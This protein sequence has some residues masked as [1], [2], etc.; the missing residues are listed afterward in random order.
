MST[1]RSVTV[2]V[3]TRNEADNVACLLARLPREVGEVIFVDDS[4]DETPA[5]IVE[6]RQ[7][8]AVPLIMIHRLP[9]DRVGGLS[10]AVTEG[11]RAASLSWV[12]VI[13]GDLQHPPEV[14]TDLVNCAVSTDVDIVVACR[15]GDEARAAMP[16][17]RQALSSIAGRAAH[18]AF[19]RR[20]RTADPMSGCFMIRRSALSID[21][22]RADGFKILLEVLVTHPEALVA[23]V[24]YVFAQRLHGHSKGTFREGLRYGRHLVGLYVRAGRRVEV[25]NHGADVPKLS[26]SCVSDGAPL[27]AGPPPHAFQ[28]RSGLPQHVTGAKS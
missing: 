19:R 9:G 10:G 6:A 18:V 26:H 2:V 28:P 16:R 7:T 1:E 4:D 12:C 21:R 13:D 23:E 8:S 27:V 20:L 5:R 22:L 11:L 24:P 17:H 3:P 15:S 14:I 25:G